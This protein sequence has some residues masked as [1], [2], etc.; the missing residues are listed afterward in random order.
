MALERVL[1][2]FQRTRQHMAMVADE[3]GSVVGMVTLEDVLEELVGEIQ[4]E[5]DQEAP[6]IQDLGG[7]EYLAEGVAP[8]RQ[9]N[10]MAG[11]NFYS[12]DVD[13]LGGFVVEQLGRLPSEGEQFDLGGFG[14][15][16]KKMGRRRIHQLHARR[17]P[18][19]LDPP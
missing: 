3:Y 8:L 13:T 7:G 17:K 1:T 14:W 11:T 6:A 9:F 18:S 10:A 5:F 16:V 2:T 4:D 15:T 12:D 19:P